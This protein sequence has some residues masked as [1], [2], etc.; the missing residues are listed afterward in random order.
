MYSVYVE[1]SS[2]CHIAYS[3]LIPSVRPQTQPSKHD[4]RPTSLP[5]STSAV[6]VSLH[7][8]SDICGARPCSRLTSGR[9]VRSSHGWIYVPFV[10]D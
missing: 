1:D 9:P 8:C 5:M 7:A 10:S 6:T 4:I 3:M 2:C